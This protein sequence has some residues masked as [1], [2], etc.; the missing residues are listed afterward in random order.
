M[1][2]YK[3][4][5]VIISNLDPDTLDGLLAELINGA[6]VD[7]VASECDPLLEDDVPEWPWIVN[8]QEFEETG[9]I[10]DRFLGESN[11]E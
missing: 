9:I 1:T 5:A 3:F 6:G 8:D 4:N 2:A 7:V 10:V 11:D